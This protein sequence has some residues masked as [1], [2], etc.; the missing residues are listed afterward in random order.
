MAQTDPISRRDT[1]QGI[2]ALGTA[3]LL[4][5][6]GGA[7][8]AASPEAPR[9]VPNSARANPA[10]VEKVFRTPLIDTHEHLPE[11]KERLEA[12]S[13]PR[14]E[15][16]DWSLLLS[17]YLDSDLAVAGMPGE[18]YDRFFSAKTDPADKWKLLAPYWP[19]VK[20]T[21][22]GQAVR[23]AIRRLYDVDDLSP[24][25]VKK[26][27]TGFEKTCRAG[28]YRRILCDLA[29]IESCQV[30]NL[31][32]PFRE[33][34]MPALLM[35]DLSILGMYAGPNLD[36]YAKPAEI[37]VGSLA[38]WHRV[39]DWWFDK[40]G[41]YAVAVKSQDAYH[42]DI[43][44]EQVPAE[45]VEGVFKKRLAKESLTGAEKK[46][47]EDHLFWQAV[48]KATEHKLPVKLHTGYYAGHN[49]MPLGRLQRNAGSVTDLCRRA[50]ETR[51]VFM[52]IC[53]PYYEELLAAAKH[54][55]N[56]YVDMCWSWIINPV[57]AKDFL[58][59][60]LVT[61]PANKILTFGGDYIPVEPVLGHATMARQ[62]IALALSELVEEGWLSLADAMDLIDPIM[63]GN[64]RA[65]FNLAGKNRV[66]QDVPWT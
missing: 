53:Y 22:Y 40:Y 26:V 48:Q 29:K 20:N 14:G 47:L 63:H 38:D 42:R 16:D 15:A 52:H 30:N 27:Q 45:K 64:A 1:L 31:G 8:A 21:G 39:I 58:R 51:F 11:E 19:A 2:G 50:P 3:G 43:D 18:T 32:E 9:G 33:T 25:T 12:A 6:L 4:A 44:Y 59:K 54:Y 41:K 55:A 35:Q 37:E 36:A 49:Y 56:A 13:R 34:E 62:G 46:S 24:D 5:S 61:A 57:A 60:F 10:I 17:H 28:F 65:I 7:P 23:I 66:L